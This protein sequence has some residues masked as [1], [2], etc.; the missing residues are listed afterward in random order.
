MGGLVFLISDK[1]KDR[2]STMFWPFVI[3]FIGLG[4]W[5]I[6]SQEIVDMELISSLGY[7]IHSM[8]NYQHV[9]SYT[10]INII[11]AIIILRL[12]KKESKIL[13]N[14]ILVYLGKI[15][16][17]MYVFHM[18]LIGIFASVLGK[19]IINDYISFIIILS[20]ILLISS[21]S[22]YLFE[23]RFLKLK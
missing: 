7:T 18:L 4:L 16:Y 6:L 19:V 3:I 12:S 8:L 21:V 17:G 9:W 1:L 13:T 23:K 20:A 10:I 5:N 14:P 22:Y 11:C 2:I 15:S